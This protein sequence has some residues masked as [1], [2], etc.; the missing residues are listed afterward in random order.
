MTIRVI[1]IETTGLDP[2]M[3]AIVEIASVDVLSDWTIAN[4]HEAIVCPPVP[5]PPEASAVHH[6]MDEDVAGKPPL[7]EV[8]ELF[9]GADAYVAH[10]CAFEQS[11]L[12]DHLG[13]VTG[14][15]A[16]VCTYKC[17]LRTWPDWPSHSNQAL[18]YR[19]GLANP[20][21]IARATLNPHRA[22]ADAIVTAAVFVE[23]M[24]LAKWPDLLR[25]SAEPA[26]HTKLGFGK[27]KGQ[28]YDAVPQDYLEWILRSDLD[29]GVKFSARH[30]LDKKKS[31]SEAS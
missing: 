24:K 30:W 16:W 22:L 18:R 15:E 27:H 31:T 10:N 1:D 14:R 7:R 4:Q 2:A 11:F 29:E 19:L 6:L 12:G 25:W 28:R 3:D 8:L 5:I 13:R 17:A 23:V 9:E 26:L 20:F 21:G